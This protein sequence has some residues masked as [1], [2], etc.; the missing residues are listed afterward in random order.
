VD[1]AV[2]V[3]GALAIL[4]GFALAQAG[5]LDVRSTPYLTLNFVG[6]AVLAVLAYHERQWGFLL[7]EGVWAIVSLWGF[8]ARR[9]GTPV[10]PVH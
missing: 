8:Y 10:A 5:R 2:Q 3:V 1:Q 7:L 6:S 4:L 9:R